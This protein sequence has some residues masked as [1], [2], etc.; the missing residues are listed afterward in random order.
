MEDV[1]NGDSFDKMDKIWQTLSHE[2]RKP[3]R[4]LPLGGCEAANKG[5]GSDP[6]E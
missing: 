4:A 3:G 6:H 2:N 5:G 1:I